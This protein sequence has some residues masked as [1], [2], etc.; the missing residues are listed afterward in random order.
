MKLGRTIRESRTQNELPRGTKM[1]YLG[2]QERFTLGNNNHVLLSHFEADSMLCVMSCQP[3]MFC[4][5]TYLEA[6]DESA[7]LD[8]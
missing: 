4:Y 7:T 5:D 1:C 3:D 2:K 6:I 8:E